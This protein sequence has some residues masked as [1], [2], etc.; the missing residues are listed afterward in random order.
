MLIQL[1]QA[2]ASQR[3]LVI[4]YRK[5]QEDEVA[6]RTIDPYGIIYWN[7]KWYTVGY[8]Q[9]R[10]AIRSFRI[11]RITHL[12]ATSNIFTRPTQFSA[13]QFFLQQL[14]PHSDDS[15]SFIPLT[16]EGRAE[17]LDD[18]CIHWLLGHYL[19]KRE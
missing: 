16:I 3:S 13:R 5:P 19:Q 1:E 9:L 4:S 8:C 14:L 11:E 7:N 18:L 2:I 15:T 17:A 10:Q 6:E 12:E